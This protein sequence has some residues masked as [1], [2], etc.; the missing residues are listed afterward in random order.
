MKILLAIDEYASR[1][2]GGS[3]VVIARLVKQLS[4]KHQVAI[5]TSHRKGK[6]YRKIFGKPTLYSLKINY[7]SRFRAWLSL[8][9]PLIVSRIKKVLK[10]YKPDVVHAHTIHMY[11]TYDLLRLSRQFTKRVIFTGHDVM[12]VFYGRLKQFRDVNG[13]NIPDTINIKAHFLK[14]WW[15]NK[16][17][18]FPLRNAIIKQYLKQAKVVT[19]S[20]SL[21]EV[22]QINRI[23]VDGVVHNGIDLKKWKVNKA[24][25]NKFKEKYGLKKKKVILLSGRL[26]EDKGSLQAVKILAKLGENWRLLIAGKIGGT[27]EQM[28]QLAQR[29]GIKSKV[30]PLGFLKQ[31]QLKIIYH[32]AD[33]I[34]VPSVCFDS[35]PNAVI[36]GMAARKVVAAT[37]F[38]GAK[39]VIQNNKTGILINPFNVKKSAE[40][41]KK[42]FK[43]KTIYRKISAAAYRRIL[44]DFTVE[45]QVDKYLRLYDS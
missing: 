12:P 17:H 34:L 45:K 10:D 35:F 23:K 28:L 22:Y 27:V 30:I 39:E 44:K 40:Q 38:G 29:L 4:K 25:S 33:L 19:V 5:L 31:S 41:I 2:E 11:L 13:D 43:N 6:S 36:E 32:S 18:F 21:K 9:N 37:I 26:R 15:N 14:Q 1:A 8:F 3:N 20:K 24:E 7:P 42:L 16:L